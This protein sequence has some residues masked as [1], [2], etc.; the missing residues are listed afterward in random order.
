MTEAAQVEVRLARPDELD[1]APALLAPEGWDFTVDELRRLHRLGGAVGAWEEGRL[2]GFLTFV[3]LPPARWVGNVVVAPGGRGRGVGARLVETAV[4][5]HP[6]VG[7]YAVE[8]AVTLYERLGFKAYGGAVA[9]RA[10]EAQPRRPT[11]TD[12]IAKADLLAVKR[13]DQRQTTLDRGIL[14]RELVQAYPASSLLVRRG[15]ALAGYGIAKTYA[16]V[17]EIGPVVAEGGQVGEDL[18]D[19][20]LA[21][22]AGPHEATVLEANR[23]ALAAFEA[24]GFAPAFRTVLMHRGPPLPWR[25][26]AL[27]AA[28]GPEKG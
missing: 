16:G 27:A 13:F 25:T 20:L 21:A 1:Q 12:R 19:A 23:R 5:G 15:D 4:E 24:R 9:L 17:T 10:A 6:R 22:T 26:A 8:K 18:L 28:G 11:A 2:V 3:D 7:L 14:L